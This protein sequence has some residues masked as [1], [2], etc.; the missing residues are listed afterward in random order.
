MPVP[1][2]GRGKPSISLLHQIKK[3]PVSHQNDHKYGTAFYP[4][5]TQGKTTGNL[6]ALVKFPKTNADFIHDSRKSMPL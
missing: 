2:T 6:P 1:L 5:S 4:S 3:E